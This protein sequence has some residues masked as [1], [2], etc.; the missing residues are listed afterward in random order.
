MEDSFPEYANF[1]VADFVVMEM[2]QVVHFAAKHAARK[3]DFCEGMAY[4]ANLS[5]AMREAGLTGISIDR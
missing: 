3:Y 2:A 1:T 5:K 4:M